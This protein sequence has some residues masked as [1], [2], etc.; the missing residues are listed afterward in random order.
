MVMS[1]Y[2]PVLQQLWDKAQVITSEMIDV[3]EGLPMRFKAYCSKNKT[4][5]PHPALITLISLFTQTKS[6]NVFTAKKREQ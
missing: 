5:K 3:F 2:L 1:L 4:K 6:T